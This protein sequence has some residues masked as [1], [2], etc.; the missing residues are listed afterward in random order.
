VGLT[1]DRNG[2]LNIQRNPKVHV[3]GSKTYHLPCP[4]GVDIGGSLAKMVRPLLSLLQIS[5]LFC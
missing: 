5:I 1:A 4:V 3:R 2:L